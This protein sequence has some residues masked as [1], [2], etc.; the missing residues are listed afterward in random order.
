MENDDMH[1]IRRNNGFNGLK[2]RGYLIITGILFLLFIAMGYWTAQADPAVGDQLYAMFQ[3]MVVASVISDSSAIMAFQ[4]FINNAQICALMFLGGATFGL[5]TMFFLVT[6]GI[7]IG[8]LISVLLR[9]MSFNTL[10][11]GLLPHGIF[12]IPAVL[13]SAALGMMVAR[14]LWE[15]IAGKGNVL[16][17]AGVAG[18][19]FVMYVVP[20]IF[21]AAC[22]EG[23][24][25]PLIVGI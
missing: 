2:L 11:L 5:L 14:G 13:I 7:V 23:F 20:F 22:V 8:A 16:R 24:I 3:E 18:R 21:I 19:L 17:T 12:E 1:E 4:I 15:E 9:D 10:I 25:T 6:N